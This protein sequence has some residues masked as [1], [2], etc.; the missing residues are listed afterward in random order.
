[1]MKIRTSVTIALAAALA[2][3][4]LGAWATARRL[5]APEQVVAAFHRWYHANGATTFNN[6]YWMGVPMQKCPLDAWTYQEILHET[7]PDVLVEAGTYKGGSAFFFAS[8][9]DLMKHGRVITVDIEDYPGKPP[10]ERVNFLLG[11]STSEEILRKIRASIQ[12]GEKVMVALDSDHHKAHVAKELALPTPPLSPLFFSVVAPCALIQPLPLSPPSVPPP[13]TAPRGLWAPFRV[14]FLVSPKGVPGFP[15]IPLSP[16][17]RPKVK[18]RGPAPPP[19]RNGPRRPP[20]R[21]RGA[22]LWAP[23]PL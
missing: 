22:Y 14:F 16:P 7:K 18:E 12:P 15:S 4:G 10:H 11:S 3:T 20:P 17:G 2:G 6:T 5:R 19:P 8:I 21:G 1:M 9:F 13:F 23:P